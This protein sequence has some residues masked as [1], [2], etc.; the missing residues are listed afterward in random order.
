MNKKKIYFENTTV[1]V[2][3]TISQITE[4]LVESGCTGIAMEYDGQGKISSLYFK[5]IFLDKTIPFKLPCRTGNLIKTF[6]DQGQYINQEKAEMIAW[7]QTYH[8]VKAQLAMIGTN[9]VKIYEVFLPYQ[10][11]DEKGTTLYQ[12]IENKGLMA[13]EYKD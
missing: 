6:K 12:V 9:M 10:Q 2:S 13:L 7:R 1:T 11:M 5:I 4:M 3:K 8:W